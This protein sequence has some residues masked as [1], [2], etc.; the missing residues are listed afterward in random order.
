MELMAVLFAVSIDSAAA[1]KLSLNPISKFLCRK[2]WRPHVIVAKISLT[3]RLFFADIHAVR[4]TN[5]DFDAA[6]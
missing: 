4:I 3:T 2:L 6:R 5:P 1:I